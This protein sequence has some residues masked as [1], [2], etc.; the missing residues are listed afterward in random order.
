LKNEKRKN[1]LNN[2]ERIFEEVPKT[3]KM[4]W[5]GE[6]GMDVYHYLEVSKRGVK[7]RNTKR[8]Y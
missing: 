4:L 5:G 1:N 3:R 6:S 7:E 2:C 8:Q